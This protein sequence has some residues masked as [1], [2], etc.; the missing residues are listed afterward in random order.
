MQGQRFIWLGGGVQA[1][2]DDLGRDRVGVAR[3]P[4]PRRTPPRVDDGATSRSAQSRPLRV[5]ISRRRTRST[6]AANPAS[7][8]VVAVSSRTIAGPSSRSPAPSAAR[9]TTRERRAARRG[10]NE[11]ASTDGAGAR[12]CRGDRSRRRAAAASASARVARTATISTSS[13][14][15]RGRTSARTS[16]GTVSRSWPRRRAL[17]RVVPA[18]AIVSVYS[19]PA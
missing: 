14:I 3:R 1:V 18:T 11:N 15:E 9:S 8:Y 16:R 19:W 17:R 6:R 13:S 12:P 7:R 4:A 10:V 5:E 2:A